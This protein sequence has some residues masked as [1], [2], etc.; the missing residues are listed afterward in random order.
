MQQVVLPA[1]KRNKTGKGISR[2]L[3]AQ[4]SIPGIVYGNAVEPI[5]IQVGLRGLHRALGSSAG[6]NVLIN[7]EI[8]NGSEVP[9][10]AGI[11]QPVIIKD[12]QTDPL[13]REFIHVDFYRI[14][15]DKELTTHVPV[16][17]LGI[18]VGVQDGGILEYSM[19]EIEVRCLPTLI[20]DK[21]EVEVTALKI[22][23]TI[24]ISDLQVP[25]GVT[26]IAPLD[27]VVMTV[28]APK[29]VVEEVVAPTEITEPE[30]ITKKP[31]EEE[32]L[33]TAEGK[34]RRVDSTLRGSTV[35]GQKEEK[36][37]PAKSGVVGKKEEKK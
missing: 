9:A 17:A 31:T 1:H 12:L 6:E 11:R 22:G 21:I 25:Q 15:L 33:D 19:R 10:K 2:Q 26:L 34:S 5:M 18:P 32:L 35:T 14:S 29:A 24:H 16:V 20:P 28:S 7:L 3:R 8:S 37:E 4:N 13:S 23:K 30:L 36:C 27:G